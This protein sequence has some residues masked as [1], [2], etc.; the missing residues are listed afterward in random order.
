MFID[1]ELHALVKLVVYT[2]VL[3]AYDISLN[4]SWPRKIKG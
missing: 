4:C 3:M 2:A 1:N